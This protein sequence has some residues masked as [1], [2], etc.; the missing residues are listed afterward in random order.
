MRTVPTWLYM[1][2]SPLLGSTHVK[3]A[4]RLKKAEERAHELNK[5]FNFFVTGDWIY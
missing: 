1:K 4:T 2:T 5:L 3:N